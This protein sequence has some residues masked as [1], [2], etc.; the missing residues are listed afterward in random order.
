MM[1][2]ISGNDVLEVW[3]GSRR[4]LSDDRTPNQV[5]S[6]R[7]TQD[8]RAKLVFNFLQSWGVAAALGDVMFDMHCEEDKAKMERPKRIPATEL[9]IRACEIVDAAWNEL[10][11]RGWIIEIPPL[12]DPV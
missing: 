4:E 9:A 6:D 5:F 7:Q 2:K 8:Q 10:R 12:D 3:G 1:H 11:H